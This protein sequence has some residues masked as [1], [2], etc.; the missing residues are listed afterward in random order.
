MDRRVAQIRDFIDVP[1]LL[2][3]FRAD[4]GRMH[5]APARFKFVHN[6]IHHLFESDET[7][8]SFFKRT[9]N[10]VNEFAT[11][12]LF[13]SPVAFDHA[14]IGALDFFVSGEAIFAFQ[15]L[16][17]APDG[18]GV[19]GLSGIHDLVV[20]RPALSTTHSVASPSNTPYLAPSKNVCAWIVD[21][22]FYSSPAAT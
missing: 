20:G 10:A 18:G 11:I 21:F 16:A 14:Q 6:L 7:N 12:E 4:G 22:H 8:G 1:Q 9:R 17:S 2:Q 3:N 15:T 19:A 5:F 13:M